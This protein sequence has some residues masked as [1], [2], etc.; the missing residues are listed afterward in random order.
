MRTKLKN[1]INCYKN[2]EIKK[3]KVGIKDK[4]NLRK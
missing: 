1:K 2:Q 3:S 4:V